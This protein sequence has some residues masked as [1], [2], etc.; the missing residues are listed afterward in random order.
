MLAERDGLREVNK[1]L[2]TQLADIAGGAANPTTTPGPACPGA[3]QHAAEGES[4][5]RR[6]AEADGRCQAL[7]DEKAIMQ[8]K[9]CVAV[10]ACMP[11][12]CNQGVP[13]LP[14]SRVAAAT[15]SLGMPYGL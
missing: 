9:V 4:Q 6:L 12:F 13:P 1:Q 3:A 7:Q 15:C 10:V 2:A 8:A 5:R 11:F 14:G